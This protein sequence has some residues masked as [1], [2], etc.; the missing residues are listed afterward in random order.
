MR[1]N[2]TS[3]SVRGVPGDGHSYRKCPWQ[4]A[5]PKI[6]PRILLRRHIDASAEFMEHDPARGSITP[7]AR[8]RIPEFV[9]FH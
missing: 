3:G 8:S 2:C 6:Y 7:C 1:E 5:C 4:F 9:G